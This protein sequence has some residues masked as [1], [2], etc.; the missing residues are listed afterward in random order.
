MLR[1]AEVLHY[2]SGFSQYL[3][4]ISSEIQKI[5]ASSSQN[6]MNLLEIIDDME[7]NI[8]ISEQDYSPEIAILHILAYLGIWDLNN[9]RFLLKR[10]PVTQFSRFF[11]INL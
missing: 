7:L 8:S 9:L 4:L 11:L 2:A 6:T 5:S 10:M 1:N 3:S